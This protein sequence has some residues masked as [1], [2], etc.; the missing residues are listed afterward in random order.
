[1]NEPR[2]QNLHNLWSADRQLQNEAFTFILSVTDE[3]VDWAYE[4][5]DEI[6]RKLKP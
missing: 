3:P 4:V 2:E 1:M 5:W 6:V